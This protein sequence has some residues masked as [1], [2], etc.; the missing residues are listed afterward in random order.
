MT[1]KPVQRRGTRHVLASLSDVGPGT[2]T[3][4]AVDGRSYA[5]I[6]DQDR[7]Y[8]MRNVCPH[9]GAPLCFGRV[10]GYMLPSEPHTYEYSGDDEEHRVVLC[11]W[12]GYKFRLTDGRNVTDPD[13]MRVRTYEV[14]V[15][16]DDVVAYL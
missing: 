2:N 1:T 11:P 7:L 10:Q 13:R 4:V 14:L 16:G 6:N 8:L 15:E 9:H 3:E 5:L 12:H